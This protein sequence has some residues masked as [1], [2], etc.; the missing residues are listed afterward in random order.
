[1]LIVW[2]LFV[3]KGLSVGTYTMLVATGPLLLAAVTMLKRA[4][5]RTVSPPHIR[6]AGR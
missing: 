6:P 3:P 1:M 2:S 4:R 5:R